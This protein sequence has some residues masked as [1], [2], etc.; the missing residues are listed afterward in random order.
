MELKIDL[1]RKTIIDALIVF[2]LILLIVLAGFTFSLSRKVD[3]LIGG[4]SVLAR[5]DLSD[6]DPTPSVNSNPRPVGKADF[7][8]T[9]KDYL[10]GNFD[11]PVTLVVYSDVQCPYSL[12]HHATMKQIMEEYE[13]KARLVWRHYPLSF[14]KNAQK[15]SEAVECAGEQGKFWE[16]LD[17]LFENQKSLS[18]ANMKKWAREMGLNTSKFDSC[19][20]DGKYASKVK[21][22]IDQG[23]ANG[24]SG[25]PATFVNG[26]LV[27]GALPFS[28]FKSKIDSLL[29]K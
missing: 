24:V 5:N 19:L 12:R 23:M 21:S 17:K 1:N 3:S 26:E 15:G 4:E 9:K 27:S 14:H 18:E 2:Q 25:T 8:I 28:Q 7:N 22:N 6:S 10:L 29:N 11:A 20:D 16:Y 13:G